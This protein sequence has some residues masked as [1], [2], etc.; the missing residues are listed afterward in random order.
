MKRLGCLVLLM[1]L[2]SSAHAATS[3]SFVVGGYRIHLDAPRHCG[4]PSCVSI[5]IPDI[6]MAGRHRDRNEDRLASAP[7][8]A[9][10]SMPPQRAA[11]P[12]VAPGSQSAVETPLG[13]PPAQA[14]TA[15]PPPPV[16]GELAVPPSPPPPPPNAEPANTEPPPVKLPVAPTPTQASDVTRPTAQAGSA[17]AS[18]AT[19]EA[20]PA[21]P[22]GD[23]RSEGNKG[24]VRIEPCGKALCGYVLD[25]SSNAIG[26]SVLVNMKPK[27][28]GV[29]S[30]H[31]YS[32][33]SGSTYYGTIA[34][35][36]EESLKVEAC[37]FLSFLC[38]GKI[39]SRAAAPQ[40]MASS[41][42]SAPQPRS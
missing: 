29:W 7:D 16:T 2:S 42:E 6:H 32:R 4:S 25:S 8:A 39:W 33:A 34:M 28:A 23:W 12:S 18:P 13:A 35:K 36:G 27:S 9:E 11:A 38:S 21:T 3:F 19:A 26:E 37:A 24:L 22:L 40:P 31:I 10:A 20:Q 30:G 14:S 15:T 1:V 17:K 41:R 5:S